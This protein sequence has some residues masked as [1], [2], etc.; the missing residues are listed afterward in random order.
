MSVHRYPRGGALSHNQK[1]ALCILARQTFDAIATATLD[2]NHWRREE[3]FN[4]VGKLSLCDCIQADYLRL[5][6]HF[7]NLAGKSGRAFDTLIRAETDEA[8]IAM[9]K[10]REACA[11]AGVQL[12]YAEKICRVQYKCALDEANEKQLWRLVY[13]VRNRKRDSRATVAKDAKMVEVPF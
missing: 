10:L 8:R 7:E 4:A 11:D 3:Q 2:F 9:H 13:T 1:A 5:K 6:A 12:E